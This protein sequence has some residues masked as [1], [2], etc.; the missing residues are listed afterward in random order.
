MR[1]KTARWVTETAMLIGLV[2]V[3]QLLSKVIPPIAV[4]TPLGPFQTGQLVTGT[5]VN[6]VLIVGAFVGGLASAGTAAVLSPVGAALFG[7]IPGGLPQ[8]IPVIMV[9]NLVIVF[10][11]WIFFR[12]ARGLSPT[13]TNILYIMGAASGALLKSDVMLTLTQ[14]FIIPYFHIAQQPAGVVTAMVSLPQIVTAAAGGL[15]ALFIIPLL[16]NV[17]KIRN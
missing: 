1:N 5:L 11:M 13:P 16:K 8:M 10:I 15:L 3:S 6:L 12:A 9:G 14:R 4:P 7:I 2:I 17:L